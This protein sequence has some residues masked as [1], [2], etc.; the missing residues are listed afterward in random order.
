MNKMY[1]YSCG[2]SISYA[3]RKPKFCQSC[4]GSLGTTAK[5]S[6]R[7]K[8]KEID[9]AEEEEEDIFWSKDQFTQGGLEV[10][11]DIH[12]AGETFAD[13]AKVEGYNPLPRSG[14]EL[15]PQSPEDAMKEFAKEAGPKKGAK[16]VQGKRRG[17]PK[18]KK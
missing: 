17:R 16:K 8:E 6:R 7:T 9:A 3:S 13:M 12:S 5:S 15:K 18:K 4:G 11:I 10:D 14:P 2:V 1:C